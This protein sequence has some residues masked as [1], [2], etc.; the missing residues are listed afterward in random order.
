MILDLLHNADHYA[1]LHRSFAQA[2]EFFEDAL[3]HGV[4]SVPAPAIGF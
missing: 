3:L 1:M 4:V 2:F